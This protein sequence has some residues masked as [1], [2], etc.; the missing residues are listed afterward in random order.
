MDLGLSD[1]LVE[2]YQ[3]FQGRLKREYDR[4]ATIDDFRIVDAQR[5]VEAIQAELRTDL[6]P[7]LAKF[8][9]ETRLV[10]DG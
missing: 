9:T 10:H 8:P 1:D 4:L 7:M 6:K 2:S 5:P 3:R